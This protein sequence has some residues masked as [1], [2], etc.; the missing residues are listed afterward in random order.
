MSC[1][2]WVM[3]SQIWM[4]RVM[5]HLNESSHFTHSQIWMSP[6][7]SHKRKS[8]CR[9][10]M[11]R[12]ISHTK[13]SS[14]RVWMS[15]VISHKIRV[16]GTGSWHLISSSCHIWMSPVILIWKGHHVTFEWVRAYRTISDVTNPYHIRCHE[17]EYKTV[18][19]NII[20]YMAWHAWKSYGVATVS[21]ID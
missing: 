7:I 3:S 9:I 4:R 15:Q 1:H 17:P 20:R 14:C 6:V 8:T 10:W 21:R 16:R 18:Q 13:T 11:R 12:V 19:D 2:G 5:S